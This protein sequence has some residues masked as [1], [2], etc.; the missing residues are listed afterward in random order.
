MK[1]AAF[2]T[3]K[4]D[5]QSDK[6]PVTKVRLNK[7]VK[8]VPSKII[9]K[10][11]EQDQNSISFNLRI[12]KPDIILVES[13]ESLD[14]EAL[15][16]NT[17]M[18]VNLKSG[19]NYKSVRG[20]INELQVYRCHFNPMTRNDSKSN[21]LSPCNITVIGSTPENSGL[22]LEVIVTTIKISVSPDTINLLNRILL[23]ITSAN[24]SSEGRQEE[25]EDYTNVWESKEFN[26]TEF[27]FLK[28]G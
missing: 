8:H 22:H 1:L 18:T 5:D 14:V 26:E 28:T 6:K 15:I 13:M 19:H 24:T 21:V 16:L 27:W 4:V 11:N 20:I 3:V 23:T 2:F 17:H 9:V 12:E 7:P 10:T 25:E